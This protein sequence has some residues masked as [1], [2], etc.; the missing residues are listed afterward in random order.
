MAIKKT[1]LGFSN[2][3]IDYLIIELYENRNVII[4][5]SKFLHGF[6]IKMFFFFLQ[7]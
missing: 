4:E 7:K 5:Y 1:D 3:N 2:K 6:M